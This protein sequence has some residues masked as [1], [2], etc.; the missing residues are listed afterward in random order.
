MQIHS[1]IGA[2]GKAYSPV[3]ASTMAGSVWNYQDNRVS[4]MRYPVGYVIITPASFVPA[5]QPFVDWKPVK[6]ML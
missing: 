6:D 3:F 5:L 4:L 2:E 1:Y